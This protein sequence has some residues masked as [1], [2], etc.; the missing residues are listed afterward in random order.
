MG[1]GMG[2]SLC[3]SS[4]T[5]SGSSS[6]CATTATGGPRGTTT[7]NSSGSGSRMSSSSSATCYCDSDDCTGN[8][9][10]SRY[11]PRC[12]SSSSSGTRNDVLSDPYRLQQHFNHNTVTTPHG[13]A[14][15]SQRM[16]SSATPTH[17]TP[18]SLQLQEPSF[19]ATA[20]TAP[21]ATGKLTMSASA[22]PF[23]P[24]PT[25]ATTL[26]TELMYQIDSLQS[27]HR[28]YV[29]GDINNSS[30]RSS[31]SNSSN[32]NNRCLTHPWLVYSSTGAVVD[33]RGAVGTALIRDDNWMS[34]ATFNGTDFLHL[35]S[36]TVADQ[37]DEA[38]SRVAVLL[39]RV[40]GRC[41]DPPLQH[42]NSI[43]TEPSQLLLTRNSSCD[44]GKQCSDMSCT[45]DNTCSEAN[46]QLE[47]GGHSSIEGVPP[48]PHCSRASSAIFSVSTERIPLMPFAAQENTASAFGTVRSAETNHSG[49]VDYVTTQHRR[50]LQRH[51]SLKTQSDSVVGCRGRVYTEDM[52]PTAPTVEAMD[53]YLVHSSFGLACDDADVQQQRHHYLHGRNNSERRPLRC[54]NNIVEPRVVHHRYGRA[55][56]TLC[57][58]RPKTV[59]SMHD[60]TEV[61]NHHHND[62]C[63]LAA[64]YGCLPWASNP[65]KPPLL[66]SNC[67]LLHSQ[68][69]YSGRQQL[70]S[71]F[72]GVVLQQEHEEP[73]SDPLS[74]SAIHDHDLHHCTLCNVL[75]SD[76]SAHPS[77]K[78]PSCETQEKTLQRTFPGSEV[79]TR[80]RQQQRHN[81]GRRESG[82]AWS[83]GE[84]L[85][86]IA[87]VSH[88]REN[89]MNNGVSFQGAHVARDPTSNKPKNHLEGWGFPPVNESSRRQSRRSGQIFPNSRRR[90]SLGGYSLQG[91]YS[92]QPHANNNWN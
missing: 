10:G 18:Y 1:V 49:Q 50:T 20:T 25:H 26:E 78:C 40:A 14:V 47:G 68:L 89:F 75:F 56:E 4:C 81:S 45:T 39:E 58:I 64:S 53:N 67:D 44:R 59:A 28:P 63:R 34:A 62:N 69:K 35:N 30:S 52:W 16:D 74:P 41:T 54:T 37:R 12:G 38:S 79:V 92:T 17:P 48:P 87:S 72:G 91:G 71:T 51:A 5:C 8:L 42:P 9:E 27:V 65:N 13:G 84:R 21:A 73:D 19:T 33:G 7:S 22:Q 46:G 6:S 85:R 36:N 23:E 43:G 15:Q 70:D 3:S 2:S 90:A 82:E 86:K 24:K 31:S 60:I 83:R 32:S 55:P 11:V 61:H 57:A 29:A 66:F 88:N 76:T 77:K 80:M